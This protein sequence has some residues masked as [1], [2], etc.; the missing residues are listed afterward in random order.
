MA[1]PGGVVCDLGAPDAASA[2][3]GCERAWMDH[4]LRMNDILTVGTHNSY[5]LAISEPIMALIREMAPDRWWH[6]D[7]SHRPLAE[8]LDDGARNL[9]IDVMHDPEGGRFAHPVGMAASGQPVDP[10]YVAAMSKPGFKVLHIQDI[11]FRSSQLTFVDALTEI[12]DW[13][14]A[15]P[16]HVPI[17]I[18]MNTNDGRR[19]IRGG[20]D[21]LPFDEAAYDA[22]DAEIR[23]VFPASQL[24][25][26]D[27]VRGDHGTLREAVLQRG[28]PR[29]GEA[30]GKVFFALDEQ[31]AHREAYR[32]GRKTLEGRVYFV[33]SNETD[34]DAA[35]LTLNEL[36]DAPRIA[37]AVDA[38]F[39]VRTRADADTV[40]ARS[41]DTLRRDTLLAS[42]A[43]YVSTDYR[44]PDPRLSDYQVR[45]PGDAIALCNPRRAPERCAGVPLEGAVSPG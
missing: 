28:W 34:P 4:N 36:A 16:D 12:R 8:Q 24:I 10:A 15:H 23:S 25:T 44:R 14:A 31:G 32:G 43:Q 1:A 33:D 13:S 39:I 22:L 19:R 21:G 38:G 20:V 30:R 40:E 17:L 11:D 35:Y 18:T 2:G 45:L 9:E 42:G 5:K 6:I 3:P 41:N 29:L 26:P 7:Y 27:W 37:A